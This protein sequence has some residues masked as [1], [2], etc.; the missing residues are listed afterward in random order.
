[1]KLV[2]LIVMCLNETI[3]KVCLEKHLS[4]AF[5]VQNGLKHGDALSALFYNMPLRKSKKIRHSWNRMGHR[6]WSVLMLI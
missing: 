5:P 6:L 4:D 3:S 1:M 2:Q